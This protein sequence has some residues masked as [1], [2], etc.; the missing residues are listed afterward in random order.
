[1]RMASFKGKHL[2]KSWR[3]PGSRGAI[4]ENSAS[5]HYRAKRSRR[6]KC[7]KAETGFRIV[8]PIRDLI[9][10]KSPPMH[11]YGKSRTWNNFRRS[12]RPQRRTWRFGL[13][14]VGS[15][16]STAFFGIDPTLLMKIILDEWFGL[17]KS[18]DY[19]RITVIR[20]YRPRY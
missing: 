17:A 20:L 15:V 6:R 9:F 10:M 1:M 4:R 8:G 2:V 7:R 5:L 18:E 13:N 3:P 12:I 19:F 14:K 16:N 11:S